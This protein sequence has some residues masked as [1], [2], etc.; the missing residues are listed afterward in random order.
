[1]IQ[2]GTG[3][4]ETQVPRGTVLIVVQFGQQLKLEADGA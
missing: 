3:A 2:F 1:M 4:L